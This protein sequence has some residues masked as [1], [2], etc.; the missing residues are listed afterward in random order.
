MEFSCKNNS[1]CYCM[2][3]HLILLANNDYWINN[4]NKLTPL[5]VLE[6]QKSLFEISTFKKN[7]IHTHILLPLQ[8]YKKQETVEKSFCKNPQV[9]PFANLIELHFINHSCW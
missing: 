7:K 4:Y 6:N 9:Q 1:L 2:E 5:C 8:I 3:K